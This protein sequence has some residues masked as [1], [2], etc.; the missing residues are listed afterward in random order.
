M[1]GKILKAK[2][3]LILISLLGVGGIV[4]GTP[5]H[6]QGQALVGNATALPLGPKAPELTA[7]TSNWIN[8]EGKAFHLFDKDGK[9]FENR[10][11]VL[12][13]WTH[14]CINCKRTIPFWN[15]WAKQ[16][17]PKNGGTSDVSVVSVHTPELDFERVPANVRRFVKDKGI[18][19][20]VVIDNDYALWKAYNVQAWPTTILIDKQGYIRARWEGELNYDNSGEYRRVEQAIEQLR[21]EKG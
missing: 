14:G 6:S 21:R 7:P 1:F 16:F 15:H 11:Y 17:M 5:Q 20:P 13:F 8:T 12:T 2:F 10:V 19:F 4:A 3:S 18:I 9:P